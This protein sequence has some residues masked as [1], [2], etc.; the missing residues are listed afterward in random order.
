MRNKFNQWA[1]TSRLDL[2]PLWHSNWKQRL[3]PTEKGRIS[4]GL[5]EW[6]NP[7]TGEWVQTQT[8]LIML[9]G[10]KNPNLLDD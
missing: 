9:K 5:L 8:A 7:E 2:S 4:G 6:Q 10:W 3:K 1:S